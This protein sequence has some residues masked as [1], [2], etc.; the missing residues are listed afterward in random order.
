MVPNQK[1]NVDNVLHLSTVVAL[2]TLES[3]RITT[4]K[5]EETKSYFVS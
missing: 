2:E 1:I 4:A 3:H 5:R